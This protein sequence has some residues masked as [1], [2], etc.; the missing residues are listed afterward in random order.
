MAQFGTYSDVYFEDLIDKGRF[1]DSFLQKFGS[2]V[3]KR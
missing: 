1:A 2:V 3:C